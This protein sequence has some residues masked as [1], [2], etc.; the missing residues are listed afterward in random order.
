MPRRRSAMF[1]DRVRDAQRRELRRRARQRGDNPWARLVWGCAILAAGIIGWL[2][3]TGQLRASDYFQWWPLILIALGLA[4]L[5]RKQWVTTVVLVAIGILFLPELP[6]P[7]TAAPLDDPRRVA[8][9][10]QRWRRGADAA[11]LAA[12][13]EGCESR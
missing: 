7:A 12:D 10:D 2:D 11:G 3:H 6:F 13:G 8:A 9:D 1:D 5:P 4:H